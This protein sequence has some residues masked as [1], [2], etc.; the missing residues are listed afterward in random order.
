MLAYCYMNRIEFLKIDES[1]SLIPF[2]IIGNDYNYS[3]IKNYNE[4]PNH[5]LDICNYEDDFYCLLS[6][7]Q[8]KKEILFVCSIAMVPQRNKLF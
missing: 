4:L 8:P 7:D 2:L 1:H 3:Q 5:F 6:K